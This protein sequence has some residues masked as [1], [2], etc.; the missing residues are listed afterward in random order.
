MAA[1]LAAPKQAVALASRRRTARSAFAVAGEAFVAGVQ[2]EHVV[3]KREQRRGRE[4]VTRPYRH[5]WNLQLQPKGWQV[6]EATSRTCAWE[7]H[8]LVG[9]LEKRLCI[10][11]ARAC[12]EEGRADEEGCGDACSCGIHQVIRLDVGASGNER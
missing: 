7:K 12:A 4:E 3:E 2:A 1:S 6:M 8:A 5:V 9:R 11:L 10:A